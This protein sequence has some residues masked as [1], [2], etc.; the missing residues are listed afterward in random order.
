[1]SRSNILVTK[2]AARQ[3]CAALAGQQTDHT[4]LPPQQSLCA[5]CLAACCEGEAV[6]SLTPCILCLTLPST[7]SGMKAWQ[8]QMVH[9]RTF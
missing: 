6:H 8:L 7:Q 5:V 3:H 2:F 9:A 1:M 4:C